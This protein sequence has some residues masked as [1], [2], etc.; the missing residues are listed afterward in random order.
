MVDVTKKNPEEE[1]LHVTTVRK[2]WGIIGFPTVF[3]NPALRGSPLDRA[4]K[5]SLC[6]H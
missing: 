4:V 5:F 3:C 2:A 6:A 1:A